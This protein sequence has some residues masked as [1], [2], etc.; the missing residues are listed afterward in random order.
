MEMEEEP[1]EKRKWHKTALHAREYTTAVVDEELVARAVE[2]AKKNRPRALTREERLDIVLAQV[3]F[4][5]EHHKRVS[6]DGPGRKQTAPNFLDAV[7]TM[8]RR[9]LSLSSDLGEVAQGSI[10]YDGTA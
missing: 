5:N 4:R 9:N 8:F 1:L 2:F 3:C 7:S 10:H 6:K